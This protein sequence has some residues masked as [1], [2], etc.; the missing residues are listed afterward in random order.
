MRGER[1][2]YRVWAALLLVTA[3]LLCGYSE[4]DPKVFDD[5]GILTEQEEETLQQ[6]IAATAEKLSLDVAVVTTEDAGGK[7][8]EAYAEDFYDDHGFGYERENGSGILFLIDMD[9]REVYISAAGVAQEMYTDRDVDRM[10]DDEIMP[11]M[12][13]GNYYRACRAFVDCLEEY[14][15]NADV[16]E[17]G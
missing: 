2:R 7:S 8:A 16:A 3:I 4:L 12:K 10:L 15:T 11:Y 13:K 14:G 17:N 5:A 1:Q 6:E 9:N